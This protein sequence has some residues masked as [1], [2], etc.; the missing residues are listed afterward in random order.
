MPFAGAYITQTYGNPTRNR[1]V[2]QI[3]VDRG[4]YMN[5]RTLRKSDD[6]PAFQT[7]I[8]RV[9]AGIAAGASDFAGGERRHAA[10]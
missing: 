1:H 8:D 2:I 10:E 9:A 6:Y 5:E 3:E 4:L 7:L